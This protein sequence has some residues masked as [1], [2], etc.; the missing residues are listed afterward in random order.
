MGTTAVVAPSVHLDAADLGRLSA[1]GIS[2]DGDP[3]SVTDRPSAGDGPDPLPDLAAAIHLG[4]DRGALVAISDRGRDPRAWRREG[5][6]WLAAATEASATASAARPLALV[7]IPAASAPRPGPIAVLSPAESVSSYELYVGAAL[8][9]A[10]GRRVEHVNGRGSQGSAVHSNLPARAAAR[11]GATQWR[12]RVEP[13]PERS[14]HGL[15]SRPAVIVVPVPPGSADAATV[16]PAHP[17]ADIVLVFD[18]AHARYSATVARQV[19]RMV[20]LAFGVETSLAGQETASRPARSGPATGRS[21]S[22]GPLG[23]PAATTT[24]RIGSLPAIR[25][26]DVI[27]VRLTDTALEL[28]NRT[29]HCV[30]LRIALGSAAEPGQVHAVFEARLEPGVSL[31]EPTDAVADLAPPTRVLR[32]WSHESAEVY[33][34]GDRRILRVEASV[35]AADGRI[36]AAHAYEAR[37]GLD[38]SVTAGDLKALLGSEAARAFHFDVAPSRVVTPPP[39][40][41]FVAFESALTVGVSVLAKSPS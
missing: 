17:D 38:F 6:R 21:I 5:A 2:V 11:A 27:H 40:D 34:G 20:E 41:L 37:N 1:L 7:V 29:S 26:S 33:E 18:A 9:A 25:A 12:E 13:R 10:S 8:A 28:T 30:R 22:A 19:A 3:I 24:E 14:L 32:H 39:R 4:A 15:V 36:H 35:L 16:I 31:A 23:G